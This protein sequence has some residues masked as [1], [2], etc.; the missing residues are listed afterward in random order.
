MTF[1]YIF[2]YV[3]FI[4]LTLSV[5]EKHSHAIIIQS[6]IQKLLILY[7]SPY[8]HDKEVGLHIITKESIYDR[9]GM[10]M[11]YNNRTISNLPPEDAITVPYLYKLHT[12]SLLL[13]TLE[14]KE[15]SVYDQILLIQN[16]THFIE[17]TQNKRDIESY[18]IQN[19]QT[20]DIFQGGLLDNT[21]WGII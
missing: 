10:D 9:S 18:F 3:P 11:R 6:P 4:L 1:M 2:F 20:P 17:H 7:S 15:R 12:K 19:I 13:N 14:D 5:I 8:Y 16:Y 21:D